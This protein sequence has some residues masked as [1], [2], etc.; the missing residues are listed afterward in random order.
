MPTEFGGGSIALASLAR[1]ASAMQNHGVDEVLLARAYRRDQ[2]TDII[3][4][5]AY[6]LGSRSVMEC[7]Y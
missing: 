2:W 1:L 7:E 3:G 5:F 4:Q 6:A